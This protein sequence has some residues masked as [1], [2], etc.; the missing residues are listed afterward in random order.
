MLQWVR[1]S[2]SF[3]ANQ[4]HKWH[5][6]TYGKFPS[7]QK[8]NQSEGVEQNKKNKKKKYELK[9]N[10]RETNREESFLFRGSFGPFVIWRIL[11]F[12]RR[13]QT[14]DVAKRNPPKGNQSEKWNL[15]F[16]LPSN[17]QSCTKPTKSIDSGSHF[18]S[19]I[20]RVPTAWRRGAWQFRIHSYDW[21]DRFLSALSFHALENVTLCNEKPSLTAINK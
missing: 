15:S 14:H 16:R 6:W 5:F 21:Q 2:S 19:Y 13:K 8:S 17:F 11:C 7:N 4:R 10:K 20:R 3:V 12:L 9:I 1:S 18:P